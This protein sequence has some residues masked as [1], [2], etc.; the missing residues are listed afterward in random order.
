MHLVC[1]KKLTDHVILAQVNGA[2]QDELEKED[3]NIAKQKVS[4][5]EVDA[6]PKA[7]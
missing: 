7:F 6:Y 2:T 3:K 1:L 5:V 4:A